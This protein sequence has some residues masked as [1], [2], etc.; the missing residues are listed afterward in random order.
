MSKQVN[1]EKSFEASTAELESPRTMNTTGLFLWPLWIYW[2]WAC[3]PRSLLQARV[4]FLLIM[5]PHL[6]LSGDHLRDYS[7]KGERFPVL[8]A[9]L[10]FEYP[11]D[12]V[13]FDQESPLGPSY[14]S[15]VLLP[16][17]SHVGPQGMMDPPAF[18]L[19]LSPKAL[20]RSYKHR[21]SL[22]SSSCKHI[23]Q[24]SNHFY[25]QAT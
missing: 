17:G 2:W 3:G 5:L 23:L 18:F 9:F 6:S 11:G 4:E 7:C 1:N 13:V 8:E 10:V 24:V 25:K 20:L 15:D 12:L 19:L 22:L 14:S 21:S 16:I